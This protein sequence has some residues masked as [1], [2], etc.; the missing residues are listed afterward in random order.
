VR[1]PAQAE[2]RLCPAR[3]AGVRPSVFHVASSTH[4][5]SRSASPVHIG[6]GGGGGE[7]METGACDTR[8]RG[9]RRRLRGRADGDGDGRVGHETPWRAY[10]GCRINK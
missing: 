7:R 4:F 9:E 3:A 5:T 6:G 2:A 8:R 1:H 10:G